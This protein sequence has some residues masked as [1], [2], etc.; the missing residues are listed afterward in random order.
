MYKVL[1]TSKNL[2]FSRDWDI[3]F[4][5]QGLVTD[6]EHAGN[7]P[8]VHLI[9]YLEA[10]GSR[11]IPPSFVADLHNVIFD[12]PDKFAAFRFVPVG[13][14]NPVTNQSFRNP[15]TALKKSTSEMLIVSPFLD[16]PTLQSILETTSKPRYLLSRKEEL[17]GI[18]ENTLSGFCCWQFSSYFETAEF[19]PELEDGG[20]EPLPQN[21]HAKLFVSMQESVPF[22]FLGSANCTDPAQGRNVEFMV[23][24]KAENAPA[25][26]PKNLFDAL[27][28][29]EKSDNITLFTKYDFTA[30]V[31]L[32]AQKSVDKAIRRL[33]YELC[34]IPLKGIATLIEGGGTYNL[35]LEIDA[36]TLSIP[37]EFTIQVKPLPEQQKASVALQPQKLNAIDSFGPYAETALSPFLAFKIIH[38]DLVYSQFLL[39]ME[40]DLPSSRLNKIFSAIIDSREKFLKYLGF[41]L[42]GENTER[43]GKRSEH[44]TSPMANHNGSG[45]FT[46]APVY[47]KLLLAS[48][49]FPERLKVIDELVERLKKETADSPEPIITKEFEDFWSVFQ[50]FINIQNR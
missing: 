38:K 43:I 6:R 28:K 17:D 42:S 31:S 1:V 29:P 7:K 50:T 15:L 35:S 16:Q 25:L 18:D 40:I 44:E 23:E 20:S 12:I 32:E 5:T 27:T 3:S 19:Q 46:G 4:S 26:K 47:E 39:P 37:A 9:Q 34:K 36:S 10:S 24:L 11:H 41:L 14:P 30:R 45:A 33:K 8:L 13:I 21:L 48:S 22:W 49:R 2:T